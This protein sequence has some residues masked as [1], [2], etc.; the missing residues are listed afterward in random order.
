MTTLKKQQIKLLALII[1]LAFNIPLGLGQQSAKVIEDFKPST[2]NQPGKEFPKVD[3]EGRVRSQILA[4][5]ATH[6]LLDIG[7]VNMKWSNPQKPHM[8]G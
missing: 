8:N 1:G 5:N 7:G 6:V 4:P 3:S 2:K